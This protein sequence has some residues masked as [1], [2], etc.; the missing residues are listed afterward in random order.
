MNGVIGGDQDFYLIRVDFEFIT[1]SINL[2]DL[3]ENADLLISFT[4]LPVPNNNLLKTSGIQL[5]QYDDF[6]R[7]C[8]SGCELYLEV[9]GQT[10]FISPYFLEY[11]FACPD[12]QFWNSDTRQCEPG[13][14]SIPNC[15]TCT[16]QCDDCEEGYLLKFGVCFLKFLEDSDVEVSLEI[17]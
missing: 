15:K 13:R 1:L 7:D 12:L 2:V 11:T 8:N 14:C 16:N 4:E 6:N 10:E 3:L 17:A 9:A 5:I